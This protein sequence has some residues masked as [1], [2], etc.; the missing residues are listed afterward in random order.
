MKNLPAIGSKAMPLPAMAA[1]EGINLLD[2]ALQAWTVSRRCRVA[3]R[4]LEVEERRIRAEFACAH[5]QIKAE[6]RL[7]LEEL[8]QGRKRF[9]QQMRLVGEHLERLSVERAR[10]LDLVGQA[11]RDGQYEFAGQCVQLLAQSR[12]EQVELV[13]LLA[14]PAAH[15]TK[16]IGEA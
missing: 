5:A 3:L 1:A 6:T 7:R 15:T 13:G 8:K 2:R 10:M 12:T 14:A 4:Q 9:E 11:Q 16:Q